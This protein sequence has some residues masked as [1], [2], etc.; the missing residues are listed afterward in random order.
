MLSLAPPLSTPDA[1]HLHHP[2]VLRAGDWAVSGYGIAVALALLLAYLVVQREY[3]RRG[4]PLVLLEDLIFTAVAS[5]V[6]AKLY[7]VVTANAAL[8]GRGGFSYL[9]GILGG[10]PTFAW[11]TW[12]RKADLLTLADSVCLGVAAA[13]PVARTGCW[14]IGDDY[15]LPFTGPWAVAFPEGAPPSTVAV[16]REQ[17]HLPLNELL[18]TTVLTVHPTQLYDVVIGVAVF[19]WLF[20]LRRSVRTRGW[21]FG[22]FLALTG[23]SR[24]GMEFVRAKADRVLPFGFTISQGTALVLCVAGVVTMLVVTSRGARASVTR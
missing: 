2:L 24:F 15:G 8:F 16:F 9:G 5:L 20:S 10:L 23:L 1:V 14:A 18:P 11:L 12:R 13:V 3:V 17:F 7:D 21:L 22:L 6:G 19:V 4:I